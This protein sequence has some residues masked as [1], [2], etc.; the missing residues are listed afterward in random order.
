MASRAG[1]C[2]RRWCPGQRTTAGRAGEG[3]HERGSACWHYRS[4]A[5]K[6]KRPIRPTQLRS[7][8][9]PASGGCGLC[10]PAALLQ[11][12][13]CGRASFGQAVG[14]LPDIPPVLSSENPHCRTRH[15]SWW[16]LSRRGARSNGS[17]DKHVMDPNIQSKPSA[18]SMRC[19][20]W[21]QHGIPKTS[22]SITRSKKAKRL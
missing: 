9:C 15:R 19:P 5:M 3:E 1:T 21:I 13:K 10:R 18:E 12:P 14:C 22:K 4:Q 6:K 7:L 20:T 17:D 2:D 16:S 8:S 11:G